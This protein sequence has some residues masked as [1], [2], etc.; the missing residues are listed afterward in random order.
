MLN[1]IKEDRP[2]YTLRDRALDIA[3]GQGGSVG[4]SFSGSWVEAVEE[5]KEDGW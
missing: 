3:W 5:A 2:G 1:W 4:V